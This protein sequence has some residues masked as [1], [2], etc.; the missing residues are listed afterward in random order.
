MSGLN[1]AQK[2]FLVRLGILGGILVGGLLLRLVTEGLMGGIQN[3]EDMNVFSWL[4]MFSGQVFTIAMP[5]M[6]FVT[7]R[8][9]RRHEAAIRAHAKLSR[10]L[11]VYRILFWLVVACTLLI[12]IFVLWLG[13]HIGPVR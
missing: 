10:L 7:L 4:S 6:A 3:T 9:G 13:T 1:F 2:G 11:T 5:V 12:I 8:Y